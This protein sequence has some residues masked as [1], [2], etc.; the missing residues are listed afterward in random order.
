[1]V[2]HIDE[3]TIRPAT[4]EDAADIAAVHI[5]SWQEAYAGIVPD[6]HLRSLD[7]EAR[8]TSW[9]D[10]LAHGPADHVRTYVAESDGRV[11]GFASYGP[12][13]DEDARRGEREIYSIYLDPGT[14]GHGV[15]RDLIRT[16]LGEAGEQTPMSL[17][18]LADNTRA[19]H[20]YRR[21][22]FSPDGVE[23]LENVGGADLLEVRYRRG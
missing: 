12:S 14:W 2:E 16:V 5:R 8:A 10:H 15:A 4:T 17:W 3:V 23:R 7:P 11:L 20:F 21:H 9:A 13:R 1:M 18:V 22:G 19:R 6:E